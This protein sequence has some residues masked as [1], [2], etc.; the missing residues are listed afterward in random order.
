LPGRI[1]RRVIKQHGRVERVGLRVPHRKSYVIDREELLAIVD[2][3]DLDLPSDAEL[4]KTVILLGRPTPERLS[5]LRGPECLTKYWRLLFHARIHEALEQLIADNRLN[6]S[7]VRRR[8]DEIGQVE[9]DEIRYVLRQ[10]DM[11]LPGRGELATYIEFVAVALELY[12]FAR[13]WLPLYFPDT[14]DFARLRAVVQQDC[15]AD[16]LFQASRLPGAP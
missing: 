5:S 3:G 11:L 4:T 6:V 2:R 1:L 8:I 16:A 15:D 13:D 7:I 14:L 9:F 10:E 12:Y